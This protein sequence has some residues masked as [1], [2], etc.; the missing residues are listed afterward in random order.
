MSS[1]QNNLK[2]AF[3]VDCFPVVSETFIIDQA[4]DLI[5]RGISIEIYAFQK[6]N[7]KNIA[8]RYFDYH[9]SK[10]TTYLSNSSN[11]FIQVV[12]TLPYTMKLFFKKPDLLFKIFSINPKILRWNLLSFLTADCDLYHCH[13]GNI[14]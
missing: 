7:G 2:I 11:K 6:G 12:W 9:L 4:C 8:Q 10:R 5:D 13:F 14:G 3:I 1:P